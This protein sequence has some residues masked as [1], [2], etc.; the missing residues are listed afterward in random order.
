MLMV[1]LIPIL[2]EAST[3]LSGLLKNWLAVM[4]ILPPFPAS[5]SAW[6]KPW[7]NTTNRPPMSMSPPLLVP[8][9]DDVV[10]LPRSNLRS[11]VAPS[12]ILPPP[13]ATAAVEIA[14]WSKSEIV[15]AVMLIV[16][17]PA[18]SGLFASALTP[19]PKPDAVRSKGCVFPM[20]VT[21]PPRPKLRL[22][23]LIRPFVPRSIKLADRLMSPAGPV[24]STALVE[25]PVSKT[26]APVEPRARSCPVFTVTVPPLPGPNVLLPITPCA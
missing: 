13:P 6:I 15:P 5:A 8:P 26:F 17:A 18:L 14:P 9:N 7:F 25:M 23:L 21:L 11:C 22:L 1:P 4:L 16:P 3:R 10:M 20:M 12:R 24:P 19:A 2:D